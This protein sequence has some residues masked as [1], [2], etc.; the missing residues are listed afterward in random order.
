MLNKAKN[1]RYPTD[2]VLC[3]PIPSSPSPPSPACAFLS[4]LQHSHFHDGGASRAATAPPT[5]SFTLLPVQP[6]PLPPSTRRSRSSTAGDDARTCAAPYE[7][8][9]MTAAPAPTW[10]ARS[11]APPHWAGTPDAASRATAASAAVATASSVPGAASFTAT[12]AM[13]ASVALGSGVPAAAAAVVGGEGR[14]AAAAVAPTI[15]DAVRPG[16]PATAAAV[17]S[18]AAMKRPATSVVRA[19]SPPGADNTTEPVSGSVAT[20]VPAKARPSRIDTRTGVPGGTALRAGAAAGAAAPTGEGKKR[21]AMTS[22][23]VV[24]AKCAG[25]ALCD[26]P[27]RSRDTS[28]EPRICFTLTPA[29][30]QRISCCL[31]C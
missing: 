26:R 11:S 1:I 8:P 17:A 23:T 28:E 4:R 10:M 27:S 2:A 12:P 19:P 6:P 15:G 20:R 13:A 29:T 18:T 5:H 31:F 24:E 16:A 21:A 25:R 30:I 22:A 3:Y 7:G 14:V 9:R